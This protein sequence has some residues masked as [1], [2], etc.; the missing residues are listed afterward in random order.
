MHANATMLMARSPVGAGFGIMVP[1]K[2][3]WATS[4]VIGAQNQPQCLTLAV[5]FWSRTA[6]SRLRLTGCKHNAIRPLVGEHTCKHVHKVLP[7]YL[8]TVCGEY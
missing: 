8:G 2:Y 6:V 3:R 1:L 4:P 5:C 7:L